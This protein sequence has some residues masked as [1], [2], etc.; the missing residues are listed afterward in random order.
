ML[1]A[2]LWKSVEIDAAEFRAKLNSERR[3]HDLGTNVSNGVQYHK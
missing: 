2:V 1:R 3:E